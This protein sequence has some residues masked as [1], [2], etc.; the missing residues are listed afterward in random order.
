MEVISDLFLLNNQRKI[1]TAKNIIDIK[2]KQSL[3]DFCF[4][5]VQTKGVAER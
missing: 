5:D 4:K 2:T 3:N 1:L